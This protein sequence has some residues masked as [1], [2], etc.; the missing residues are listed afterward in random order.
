MERDNYKEEG[1]GTVYYALSLLIISIITFGVFHNPLLGLVPVLVM[2]YG[3]G[4]AAV[5]GKLLKSKKIWKTNKSIAGSI[6]MFVVTFIITAVYF[7]YLANPMWWLWALLIS[8]IVT[9]VE[10]FSIK[11]LD[12][13][14]VPLL[15][16]LL[17]CVL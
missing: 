6:T 5:I 11:G 14:T 7:V 9:I 10:L 4:L 16:L 13:I 8:A 17:V 1:L 12:N 2:A 3:D 15:T